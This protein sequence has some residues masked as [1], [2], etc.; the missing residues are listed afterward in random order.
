MPAASL[1]IVLP[2]YNEE[3]RLGPCPRRA[4]RVPPPARRAGSRRPRRRRGAAARRSTCWS[5]TTAPPTARRPSSG[6]R[7][8]RADGE[9]ELLTV[10]HGGKGAAVRAGML[11]ATGDLVVFADADMATPPDELSPLVEALET[12]D[13]ALRLADPARRLGHARVAAGWRRLAG[14]DVPRCSR[15]C[16]S[17][18][19]VQDTQCG[20]KGFRREVARDVFARQKITSIV[21]DVEVIYLVRRRGYRHA[22]VPDPLGRPARLADAARPAARAAGRLGPV[23]DPADPPRCPARGRAI[24]RSAGRLT[25]PSPGRGRALGA[26]LAGCSRSFAIVVFVARRRR[27]RSPSPAT[28]S[29]YDF[30][31]YHAAASRVLDG[32]PA[33]DMSFEAAG[34]FGLFY[35][36]PTFIPLVLP[37]GL[38]PADVATWAL[39]RGAARRVRRRASPRCRSA[40]G[41]RWITRAARGAVVA[42]PVRD[43]ARPG[44]PAAVPAV[45]ARLA[46]ARPRPARWA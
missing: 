13:A 10:P 33:Y 32:Q 39:D 23:P 2:A 45:R 11:H 9:L 43:Q 36:P 30:L 26:A 21:F 35:Y 18:G 24:H 22:V 4:V 41:S 5:S 14:Q 38:L 42:V 19:P 31:A 28:R 12:V 37:F 20:F 25:E 16:G 6:P 29:G 46:V 34:G 1:T 8:E 27:R 44:R 7:P 17:S 3:A 40:A 15:R